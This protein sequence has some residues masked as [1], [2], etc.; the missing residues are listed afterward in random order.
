MSLQPTGDPPLHQ[1]RVLGWFPD[2]SAALTFVGMSV[3]DPEVDLARSARFFRWPITRPAARPVWVSVDATIPQIG[4][5]VELAGGRL[6]AIRDGRVVRVRGHS[7]G[8]EPMPSYYSELL[9]AE[10]SAASLLDGLPHTPVPASTPGDLVVLAPGAVG[11]L[12]LRRAFGIGSV[13]A[14][15]AVWWPVAAPQQI[16][17]IY[18]R[19]SADEHAR[20]AFLNDLAEL[21]AVLVGRPADGAEDLLTDVRYRFPQTVNRLR[22]LVPPNQGW[23]V[24]DRL[25]AFHLAGQP[26]N[27][28]DLL[29]APVVCPADELPAAPRP[30]AHLERSAVAVAVSPGAGYRVDAVL[31]SDAELA[32]LR[33]YLQRTTAH[34]DAT[35]VPGPGRHLLVST[36]AEDL[37]DIPLGVPVRHLGPDGL[38]LESGCVLRPPVPVTARPALFGVDGNVLVVATRAGTVRL[39]LDRS[40]PAW[41]MWLEGPAEVAGDLSPEA[42]RLL[43][44]LEISGYR[45]EAGEA[46]E[47][48]TGVTRAAVLDKAGDLVAG[49]AFEA[50]AE[51]LE[52][53]GEQRRAAILYRRAAEQ[54]Q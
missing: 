17:G 11:R 15:T 29:D 1:V 45:P 24:S 13:R 23:L 4:H 46:D 30:L 50:A 12:I 52:Q 16:H 6:A 53:I 31:V 8:P 9:L 48:V 49:G 27:G 21:P 10:V 36:G 28:T 37:A 33:G 3:P 26:V 2:A 7:A 38:Y 47:P 35:L 42:L 44:N 20:T 54:Q 18:L 39:E 51:L 40:C 34:N 43:E 32:P 19:L 5:L 41:T 22:T 25:W 14:A